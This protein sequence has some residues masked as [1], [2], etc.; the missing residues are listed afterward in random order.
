MGFN[1]LK[2]ITRA[3]GIP[4]KVRQ[5]AIDF[6]PILAVSTFGSEPPSYLKGFLSQKQAPP[7]APP[8][9]V[10]VPNQPMP[11]G[12][13]G[14]PY[15]GGGQPY[16]G[17]GGGLQSNYDPY[18]SLQPYNP[19]GGPASWDYSMGSATY[20]VTPSPGYSEASQRPA[21]EDLA[22]AALPLFL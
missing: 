19:L 14:Q 12:T 7:P 5:S 6:F 1:P 16:Y 17:G 15:Y 4:D 20:L 22:L 8:Q 10:S 9:L 18:S 2:A 11:P 21:W 13:Y 3:V